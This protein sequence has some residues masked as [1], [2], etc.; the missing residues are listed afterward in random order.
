MT[1][2]LLNPF[3]GTNEGWQAALQ[4]AV[5]GLEVRIWPDVGNPDDIEY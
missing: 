2:L 3:R 1:M 4:D 5:D